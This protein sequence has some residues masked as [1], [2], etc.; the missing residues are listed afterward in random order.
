MLLSLK[1]NPTETDVP[2]FKNFI[3]R[4]KCVCGAGLRG[5]AAQQSEMETVRF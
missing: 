3:S 4:G 1:P 5:K 2:A